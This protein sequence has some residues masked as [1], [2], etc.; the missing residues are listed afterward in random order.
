MSCSIAKIQDKYNTNIHNII[1]LF[2]SE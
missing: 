1:R 2:P